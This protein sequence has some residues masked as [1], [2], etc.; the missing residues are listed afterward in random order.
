MEE[1]K[2]KERICPPMHMHCT[3]EKCM[4]WIIEKKDEHE[5]YCVLRE[6]LKSMAIGE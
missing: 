5:G 1:N 6:G 4:L 2:A 3:G